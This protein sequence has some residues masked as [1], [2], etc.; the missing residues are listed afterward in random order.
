MK[1]LNVPIKATLASPLTIE[2]IHAHEDAERIWATVAE[3]R[4]EAQEAWRKAW[5]EGYWEGAHQ[6]PTKDMGYHGRPI[7]S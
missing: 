3:I 6:D 4:R 5:D 1:Y 7:S 2:E